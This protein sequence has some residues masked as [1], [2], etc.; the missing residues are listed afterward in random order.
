MN[1][2]ILWQFCSRLNLRPRTP[3]LIPTDNIE[4]VENEEHPNEK[5][6]LDKLQT[7]LQKTNPRRETAKYASVQKEI[8]N[9]EECITKLQGKI[10]LLKE[11]PN[12]L[13]P[14]IDDS[15]CI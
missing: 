13:H 14:D 4:T 11:G 8:E 12:N 10:R 3:T 5:K 1:F 6:K 7:K 9:Q 15:E 2:Q